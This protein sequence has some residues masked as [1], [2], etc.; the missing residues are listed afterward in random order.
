MALPSAPQ[1]AVMMQQ[2]PRNPWKYATLVLTVFLASIVL[3]ATFTSPLGAASDNT[4]LIQQILVAV[5]SIQSTLGTLTA[6]TGAISNLQTDVTAIKERTDNLPAD[7]ESALTEIKGA[8]G[9][10]PMNRFFRAHLNLSLSESGNTHCSSSGPFLL[11]IHSH[12]IHA[13]IG[14]SLIVGGVETDILFVHA[15]GEETPMVVV[16]GNA[17]EVIRVSGFAGGETNPNAFL[18]TLITMQTT[19]GA[20]VACN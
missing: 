6:G 12:G 9:S 18:Q 1:E 13:H 4:N 7:T 16:G 15:V 11:H 17:G 8:V 3:P 2:S 10:G 20:I 14:G 19:E 5:Q